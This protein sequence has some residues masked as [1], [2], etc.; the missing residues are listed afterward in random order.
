M[1]QVAIT[2]KVILAAVL[3]TQVM[4]AGMRVTILRLGTLY[5]EEDPGNVVRLIRAIDRGRFFWIGNGDN[6]KNLL[7]RDDAARA[8]IVA[9]NRHGDDLSQVFDV[10][11]EAVTTRELVNSIVAD[12]G[13]KTPLFHV[14]A[15][16]VQGLLGTVV[17]ACPFWQAPRV[18]SQTLAKWVRSDVRSMQPFSERFGFSIQVPFQEGIHRELAWYKRLQAESRKATRHHLNAYE[19][20]RAA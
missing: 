18:W 19:K 9:A 10:V 3:P 6:R 7:H 5:G 17:V 14:P 15:V 1:E 12:L 13:R 20:R 11:G 2:S 8:C 4:P 16:L